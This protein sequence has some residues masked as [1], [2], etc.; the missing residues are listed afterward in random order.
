MGKSDDLARLVE[1][2][3]YPFLFCPEY[4][5]RVQKM[6]AGYRVSVHAP[7]SDEEESENAF[8]EGCQDAVI[9]AALSDG[10]LEKLL[11]LLD[12]DFEHAVTWI[13]ADS[14]SGLLTNPGGL[15]GWQDLAER[16]D[17][18]AVMYLE[19]AGDEARHHV[20]GDPPG[21]AAAG[22]MRL[23][24][25]RRLASGVYG[26]GLP[27]DARGRALGNMPAAYRAAIAHAVDRW[28]ASGGL[29]E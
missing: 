18:S 8:L 28:I 1:S 19:G 17:V 5:L 15:T 6:I 14:A 9:A 21:T 3:S 16:E 10:E 2:E 12:G 23:C 24:E 22:K 4:G 11:V 29:R 27:Q 13:K 26:K 20:L 25:R 7:G